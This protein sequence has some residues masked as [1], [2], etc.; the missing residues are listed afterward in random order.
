MLKPEP[1][2]EEIERFIEVFNTLDRFEAQTRYARGYGAFSK[3]AVMPS[4]EVVKVIA[5]LQ[6]QTA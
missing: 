4:P 5:W 6:K 2:K 1:T 3:G